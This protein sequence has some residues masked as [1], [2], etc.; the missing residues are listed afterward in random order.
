MIHH[1]SGKCLMR[2]VTSCLLRVL[3]NW[4]ISNKLPCSDLFTHCSSNRP[5]GCM[6]QHAISNKGIP[7]KSRAWCNVIQSMVALPY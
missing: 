1:R 5:E 6:K 4:I 3:L 2:L 7:D